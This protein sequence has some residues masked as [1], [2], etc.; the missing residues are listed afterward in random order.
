[1]EP[2]VQ[3]V[4]ENKEIKA[5]FDYHTNWLLI[6]CSYYPNITYCN[7]FQHYKTPEIHWNTVGTLDPNTT[8]LTEF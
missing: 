5:N 6:L 1:M 2:K 4:N 7:M 8:Y 3:T